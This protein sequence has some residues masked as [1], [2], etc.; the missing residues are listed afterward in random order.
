MRRPVL[1]DS[2]HY[3]N[4]SEQNHGT[5]D[6]QN[7][8]ISGLISDSQRH[9]SNQPLRCLISPN[10][11]YYSNQVQ[12]ATN[13]AI[14]DVYSVE[15]I[16]NDQLSDTAKLISEDMDSFA[17][18]ESEAAQAVA[19]QVNETGSQYGLVAQQIIDRY[20]GGHEDI[21]TESTTSNDG[22]SMK[23]IPIVLNHRIAHDRGESS[24]LTFQQE[25]PPLLLPSDQNNEN[26]GNQGQNKQ[27]FHNSR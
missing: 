2:T 10:P 19:R 17:R 20:E 15:E 27:P 12:L 5:R 23:R 8:D 26:K 25:E 6:S 16:Q 13:E 1:Q 18:R 3:Y 7:T 22:Q 24:I 11:D 4:N 14:S 21:R 9:K